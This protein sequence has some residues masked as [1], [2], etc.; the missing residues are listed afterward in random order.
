MS[1]PIT[2]GS[3]LT[4]TTS[5]R[6]FELPSWAQVTDK[7]RTHIERVTALLVDWAAAMRLD[8]AEARAWRDV[9]LWHDALRDAP[10]EELRRLAPDEGYEPNMLH[11]PAAA[12][13]LRA[14]GETRESVLLAVRYHT[15]GWADWD[16]TGR[17]LYMADFLE[18]GRKFSIEDRTFL[19]R[20]VPVDFDGVYRQ[21]VK[22]RIEWTLREGMSLFPEV[23]ALWNSVR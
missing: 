1:T 19:A 12:A 21:V 6:A 22:M 13:R 15:V 10:E 23:V 14:D 2:S 16:R 4:P 17:A 3:A 9:G 7:R 11:G 5:A 8:D 18:P 20:H